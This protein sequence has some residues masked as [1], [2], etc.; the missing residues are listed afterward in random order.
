MGA[1]SP[2][3][4]SRPPMLIQDDQLDRRTILYS[5]THPQHCNDM[6]VGFPESR[7]F[8]V[9]PAIHDHE[10]GVLLS[11][12]RFL[13]LLVSSTLAWCRDPSQPDRQ[14]NMDGT[15]QIQNRRHDAQARSG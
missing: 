8:V 15:F 9:D 2:N 4:L 10:T 14:K 3:I 13:R 1:G 11:L 7:R 5:W 12:I 6:I